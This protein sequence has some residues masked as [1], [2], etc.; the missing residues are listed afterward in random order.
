MGQKGTAMNK[1]EIQTRCQDVFDEITHLKDLLNW[2]SNG[3]LYKK[4][5]IEYYPDGE[6]EEGKEQKY[7]KKF[8]EKFK[9]I[10][11]RKPWLEESKGSATNTTLQNLNALKN[12]I[13]C[14]EDYKNSKMKDSKIPLKIRQILRRESEKFDKWIREQDYE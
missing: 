5:F 13:Y 9:K 12:A 8:K 6:I 11:S 14:C 2:K 4:T 10:F 1:Q 3:D 7:E